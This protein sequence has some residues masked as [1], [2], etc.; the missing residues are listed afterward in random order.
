MSLRLR[1]ISLCCGVLAVSLVLAGLVAYATASRR[2]RT[3][4]HAAFVV[5]RQ[6]ILSARERLREK[7]DPSRDLEALIA[8]FDGNRHLRVQLSGNKPALVAPPVEHSVFGQVPR[9][10]VDLVGVAPQLERIPVKIGARDYATIVIAT[11]PYNETLEVWSQFT[12][13]LL[14]P[15]VLYGLTILLIYIFIGRM[16]RPIDRLSDALEEVGDGRF[17]TRF[18]GR[19]PPE[20]ARLRDSFNRMAARLAATDADNR[21]LNEQLLSLQEQERGDLARDLH[22]DVGPFLFAIGVDA[23]AA[24]RLLAEHRAGE[25]GERVRSI[26]EAVRHT[27]RQ[28]RRMLGRLRPIG[29]AEF[30]LPEAIENIVGFWRRRHP[31]IEFRVAVASSCGD[32]MEFAGPTICRI[33]QE[34]LSNA[35]RHAEPRLIT[36]SVDRD[37][38]AQSGGDIRVEVADNGRGMAPATPLG[39]G[40]IGIRERLRAIGGRLSLDSRPGS[41]LI[42]RAAFPCAADAHPRPSPVGEA[43]AWRS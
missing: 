11:D 34:A 6:T 27:Q 26:A 25:A 8:S 7:D 10:F 24:S 16:L 12:D 15:A 33:V 23:A 2:V 36:I 19:L 20:L 28:V 32:R 1:L 41:G 40:L 42:V 9:W 22:D 4:M 5:G 13:G 17:R 14:A 3:E 39:Y 18:S 21:R 29:L 43:A 37:P 35:V 31:Q 30:G 38:A